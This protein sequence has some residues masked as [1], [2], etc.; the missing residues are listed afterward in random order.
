MKTIIL[1]LYQ[2]GFIRT[3][4]VA[5]NLINKYLV[6]AKNKQRQNKQFRN[7][8]IKYI[9]K[10]PIKLNNIIEKGDKAAEEVETKNLIKSVSIIDSNKQFTKIK[11]ELNSKP[12]F[13]DMPDLVDSE[14]ETIV[15]EHEFENGA[16]HKD[17]NF[18]SLMGR[19]K[20]QFLKNCSRYTR[21]KRKY[22]NTI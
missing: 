11:I 22:K 3:K 2:S 15:L 1:N 5:E 8:M 16:P 19:L 17:T 20:P 13:P 18:N 14:Y 21:E 12:A 10:S 6:S 7:Q 4:K 9:S